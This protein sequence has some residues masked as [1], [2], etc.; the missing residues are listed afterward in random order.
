MLAPRASSAFVCIRCELKL[1]RPRLPLLLARPPQAAFSSASRRR[2]ADDTAQIQLPQQPQRVSAHPL[3]RIR[4]R[5]GRADLR[6]ITARLEDIKT[7]GED[8]EI[9]VLKEAG[10]EPSEEKQTPEIVHSLAH[11]APNIIES[12]RHESRPLT[13]QDIINQLDSLRPKSP[14]PYGPHYVSQSTFVK[15]SRTVLQGFTGRQLSHYYSVTKGVKDSQVGNEVLD[16]LKQLQSRTSRPAERSEWHPGTTQID[17]RL[18]GLAVHR[19][20]KR[21]AISKHLLVDQI[22]R[23]VWKLVL[24]EE[25]E[26]PGELE[27]SLKPW[28]LSI[29]SSGCMSRHIGPYQ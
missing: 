5:R 14:D 15:L 16:G 11:E 27:L 1:A 12:L 10:V 21:G 20:P 18:P 17:Q 22:L 26:A 4:K 29:L 24:L 13:P 23:D 8:A 28:Q 9:L 2:D 6:E 25:I 19:K 7:L 3:G